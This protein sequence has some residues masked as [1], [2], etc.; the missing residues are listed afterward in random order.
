MKSRFLPVKPIKIS[1]NPIKNPSKKTWKIHHW[2]SGPDWKTLS[3]R[4][5]ASSEWWQFTFAQRGVRGAFAAD[6]AWPP[7]GR[8]K[9]G[10]YMMGICVCMYVYIY[11]HSWMG[12]VCIDIFFIEYLL[13]TSRNIHFDNLTHIYIILYNLHTH[14]HIYILQHVR[15]KY[16]AHITRYWYKW[17]SVCLDFTLLGFLHK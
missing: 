15:T 11:I 12:G 9:Y 14:V 3:P 16:A 1:W 4:P 2:A 13:G 8:C 7:W 10:W 6:A 17:L 5:A